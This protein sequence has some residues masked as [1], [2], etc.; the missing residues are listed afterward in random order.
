M[1]G[2]DAR[3]VLFVWVGLVVSRVALCLYRVSLLGVVPAIL[4]ILL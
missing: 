2:D 1:A 4:V 3:S